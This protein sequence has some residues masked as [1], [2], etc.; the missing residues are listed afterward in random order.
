MLKMKQKFLA[1]TSS[2]I[3][4]IGLFYCLFG[5]FV[6]FSLVVFAL[7]GLVYFPQDRFLYFPNNPAS[8]R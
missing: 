3:L 8:A 7:C 6:T 5:G 2:V 4:A 1:F